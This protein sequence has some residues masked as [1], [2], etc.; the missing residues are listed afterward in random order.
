M[1]I[2]WVQVLPSYTYIFYEQNVGCPCRE[3]ESTF[4]YN[5]PSVLIRMT[6]KFDIATFIYRSSKMVTVII[7]SFIA[8]SLAVHMVIL[9][10]ICVWKLQIITRESRFGR[11]C[12]MLLGVIM[13]VWD[14]GCHLVSTPHINTT[15]WDICYSHSLIIPVGPCNFISDIW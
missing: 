5:K 6:G 14:Q 2:S 15:I 13:L 3:G 11:C 7:I 9:M 4:L 8:S 10:Q 12:S 1:I